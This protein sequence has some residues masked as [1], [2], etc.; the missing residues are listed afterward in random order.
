[1]NC[2]HLIRSA[3]D[4]VTVFEDY[5]EDW[6]KK[7]HNIQDVISNNTLNFDTSNFTKFRQMI[8]TICLSTLG[9][10]GISLEYLLQPQSCE[11]V[12]P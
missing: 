1:M 11:P 4:E 12:M 8:E 5:V 6:S 9:N 10:R 2:G 3:R 7:A